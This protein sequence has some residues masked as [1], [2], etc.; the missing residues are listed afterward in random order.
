MT[1]AF[2]I[3]SAIVWTMVF[4][5]SLIFDDKRAGGVCFWGSFGM[6][7]FDLVALWPYLRFEAL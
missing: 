1:T 7:V 4:M 5:G 6:L 2:L 3:T